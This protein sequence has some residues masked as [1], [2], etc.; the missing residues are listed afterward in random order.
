MAKRSYN[1]YC[2]LA[3]ALDVLGER[4]TLLVLRELLPGQK[5]YSDLLEGLP[6]IGPNV[7]AARL[8]DLQAAGVVRRVKLPPPAGSTVYELTE[9]GR[10]LE[11]G[12]LEL[13]RWGRSL[14]GPIKDTDSY[15]LG[16]LLT[17]MRVAFQ[18]DAARGVHDTYEFRVEGEVFHVRVDD[19]AIDVRHG[20]AADPD[21]VI[22]SDY[23]T[24]VAVGTGQRSPAGALASGRMSVSGPPDAAARCAEMLVLPPVT[25]AA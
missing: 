19:G 25:A 21:V 4:W 11:P 16:W 12:L 14:L 8:K 17:G 6:G 2:P 24:M 5:R 18:P 3:R 13:A 7:L 10:D 20:A 1:E 9:V 22:T 15:R 23:E